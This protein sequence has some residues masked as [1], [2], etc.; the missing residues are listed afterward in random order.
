MEFKEEEEATITSTTPPRQ[1]R[2]RKRD[3]VLRARPRYT[4][5]RTTTTTSRSSAVV[6]DEAASNKKAA[7]PQKEKEQT[8]M[9]KESVSNAAVG[10]QKQQKQQPSHWR[11]ANSTASRRLVQQRLSEK[12]L[13]ARKQDKSTAEAPTAANE[14]TETENMSEPSMALD[15][16]RLD[17]D[18]LLK[19]DP[20]WD[21]NKVYFNEFI[22]EESNRQQQ[23]QSI[24]DPLHVFHD[25][26]TSWAASSISFVPSEPGDEALVQQQQRQQQQEEKKEAATS[27]EEE[28]GDEPLD[29]PR[30]ES[31]IDHT[32]MDLIDPLGWPRLVE[33]EDVSDADVN[34]VSKNRHDTIGGNTEDDG[35]IDDDGENLLRRVEYEDNGD[36]TNTDTCGLLSKE[37]RLRMYSTSAPDDESSRDDEDQDSV[38]SSSD[39]E[40]VDIAYAPQPAE[41]DEEEINS[42]FTPP[43]M[44]LFKEKQ[45]PITANV[46]PNLDVATLAAIQATQ[47]G[48]AKFDLDDAVYGVSESLPS[49]DNENKCE[50]PPPPPPYSTDKVGNRKARKESAGATVIPL[51][52]KPPE[53]KLKK[54]EEEKA[55]P[56]KHLNSTRE[57]RLSAVK[58]EGN[59]HDSGTDKSDSESS[60][61]RHSSG[62]SPK[63]T[64]S[65]SDL[66]RSPVSS[67]AIM[68]D[69]KMAE[70]VDMAISAASSTFEEQ[71]SQSPSKERSP[72][73]TKIS[74]GAFESWNLSNSCFIP[75]EIPIES[76]K[77]NE[78]TPIGSEVTSKPSHFQLPR[79]REALG[80]RSIVSESH[81]S[82]FETMVAHHPRLISCIIDF[83]GDPVAICRTRQLNKAC[84]DYV[85]E[86][87]YVLMREAVR[88]GG[89]SKNVRP[90]FW[91]WVT[92][93]RCGGGDMDASFDSDLSSMTQEEFCQLERLG[94]AGKWHHVIERDV[95]RAFGNLPPH[96]TGARLRTDSIVRALVWWGKGR[97]IKRG[98]RGEGAAPLA[99][100]TDSFDSDEASLTPTDTVSDWGGVDPV[101]SVTSLDMD[102]SERSRRETGRRHAGDGELALSGN[103]LAEDVKVSLQKKLSFILHALAASHEDVGYCQGMDYVVAHLLRILQ[104]TIRWQG[105][106]GTLPSI[107][108]SAGPGPL[109]EPPRTAEALAR[110]FNEI[111]RTVVVEE[112]CFRVMD[113]FFTSYNLRHFFFPELRCLKT[114]CRVFEKLVQL[115]LPV[116]AD[117]F[118]HH[119]LNVGL[120]ALGWFQTLFLYL[121]SMPSATVCHMWDIWLVERSFKIFFR[122]GTAILFLSQPILLNH[123]LEGMMSYLNTFP[124]AT[125]L[126]PDILIPCALQI[127]VTNKMLME[128]EREVMNTVA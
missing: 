51:I 120:F 21:V 99:P 55:R 85:E 54:W 128:L 101:G 19:T 37:E 46:V 1:A 89:I 26:D 60:P 91:L 50:A 43:T 23:Q 3:A 82:P 67:S 61:G 32:N 53:E 20:S 71:V 83:I 2:R 44:D 6:D 96:K 65:S 41:D 80:R 97:M 47:K 9:K 74:G 62:G 87:E 24:L 107:I 14:R 30:L 45:T 77:Q 102:E 27:E 75:E 73:S 66:S 114:C 125:P 115:K 63:K 76:S 127:K 29:P 117:H 17:D 108:K 119:E 111:D 105:A 64:K 113:T 72:S 118:E 100:R 42:E 126:S 39:E 12:R 11:G 13:T 33:P 38:E 7:S 49:T 28:G 81:P 110:R 124:D 4:P 15:F 112:T 121:P 84:N 22:A 59:L 52:R 57:A 92:L 5:P 103:H 90:Y 16:R 18:K 106:K 123:E 68:Q 93:E 56:I 122:V 48:F 35:D 25:Q 116:L 95:S 70:K 10:E 8:P 78:V 34:Q 98:V 31:S 36:N 94:K 109:Y 104:E 58:S 88:A 86:N 69:A 40:E 79:R